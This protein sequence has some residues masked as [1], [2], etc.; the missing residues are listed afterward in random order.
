MSDGG[1]LHLGNKSNL[2]ACLIDH[3]EYQSDAPVISNIIIDGAF[4][5]LKLKPATVKNF[6][7]YASLIFMLYILL[8]FQ[9]ARC[10]D[11]V[12]NRYMEST[13]KCTTT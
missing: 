8:Q 11:L 4:I 2:L 13:L 12:W 6:D 3:S 9:Y 7:E 1:K 10:V 5:V